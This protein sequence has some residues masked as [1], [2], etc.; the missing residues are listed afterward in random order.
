MRNL[1]QL[2]L[3]FFKIRALFKKFSNRPGATSPFPPSSYVPGIMHTQ[4]NNFMENKLS[5]VTDRFYEK[6]QYSTLL[7]SMIKNW[8]NTLDKGRFVADLSKTFDT[9]NHD[10]LIAKLGA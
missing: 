1:I 3:F 5:S 7:I 9:L 4:I 10:L 2:W 6:L 8:E